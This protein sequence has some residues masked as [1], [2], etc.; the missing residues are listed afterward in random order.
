[1]SIK[2]IRNTMQEPIECECPYC[3]SIFSYNYEDIRRKEINNL[4]GS[5]QTIIFV[6][7]PVCKFDI[8]RRPIARTVEEAEK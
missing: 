3:G 5:G 8:D 2:I 6:V 7:C 4:L 1:M